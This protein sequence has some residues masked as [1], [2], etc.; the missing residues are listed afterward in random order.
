MQAEWRT[1]PQQD[2]HSGCGSSSVRRGTGPHCSCQARAELHSSDRRKSNR[3]WKSR[4]LSLEV[5]Q[6]SFAWTAPSRLTQVL[7]QCENLTTRQGS[8]RRIEAAG[9]SHRSPHQYPVG[10]TSHQRH[11]QSRSLAGKQV[12]DCFL[13]CPDFL[14]GQPWAA[15]QP[16]KAQFSLPSRQQRCSLCSSLHHVGTEDT[17]RRSRVISRDWMKV[18]MTK[19]AASINSHH[20]KP[21]E[22][23]ARK[24]L[25]HA[26]ET[27]ATTCNRNDGRMA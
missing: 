16:A 2:R 4:V 14:R 10:S 24:F 19:A 27:T 18:Q 8:E 13:D 21:R 17:D 25:L 26:T 7:A 6:M 5:A 9:E 11:R 22:H 1:S 15:L 3:S 20:P 23:S 12:D